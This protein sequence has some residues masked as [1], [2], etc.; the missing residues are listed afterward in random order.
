MITLQQ[1]KAQFSMWAVMT[2]PL[3]ISSNVRNM[4]Q[5]YI[6]IYSN[7][8][9]IDVNQD[10][11]GKQGT[12][13]YGE[14]LLDGNNPAKNGVNI[15]SKELIDGSRAMVFINVGTNN[16]DIKCDATC[17]QNA[18]FYYNISVKVYDLWNNNKYIDTIYTNNTFIVNDV[19]SDGGVQMYRMI[20]NFNDY[21]S[22]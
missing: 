11:M 5:E 19:M 7:K 9:I 17:F 12:R 15:W 18:G 20:P 21:P 4:A 10:K 16:T 2:A 1:S 6:D 3:L 8:Y 13:I 22:K 14:S